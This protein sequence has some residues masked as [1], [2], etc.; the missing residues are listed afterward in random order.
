M[1]WQGLL[2]RFN[3][4]VEK[5]T[6]Q[7]RRRRMVMERLDRREV[8]A[9]NIGAIGGVAF[10]DVNGNST[11]DNGTDI[12][13]VGVSV[14]LFNDTN[15]NGTYDVG[16]D[17]LAG[18]DTTDGSGVYRF[19]GLGT[20]T[21]FIEQAASGSL[22]A[23]G[24]QTVTVTND[25]GVQVAQ[26]DSYETATT[27]I[28]A[29]TGTPTITAFTTAA[30]AIGGER[31]SQVTYTAGASSVDLEVDAA[32][33]L[34][35]I[36]SGPGTSGVALLQYDGLDGAI[37]LDA[38]GLANANLSGGDAAS[39]LEVTMLGD[40]A[41][42]TLV[43][44]IYTDGANSS[45]TTVNIPS[46]GV[47]T[48]FFVPFTTFTTASGAGA[49]FTDVGAIEATFTTVANLDIQVSIVESL[50]PEVV[51][52]NLANTET[53]E[54]GGV[55][56][57]D[58]GPNAG[59]QNNGTNDASEGGVVG[60]DVS[61][62]Q[63]T[64]QADT[65]T[66]ASVAL[67]TTTTGVGGVY[68]FASLTPGFYIVAIDDANFAGAAALAGTVSSTGNDPAPDPDTDILGDDNGT[69]LAGV[70]VVTGVVELTSGGEPTTDGDA[71]NNTNL[72][73][74]F[75]VIP[76][77]D[78]AITKTV[79]AASEDFAGGTALFDISV[80][81][82]GP[83]SATN[84]DFTDVIP[85]GL[86]FVGI[87]NP[88]A[89]FT[90]S[91]VGSTLT[92]GLGTIPSSGAATFQ[93]EATIDAGRTTDITNTGTVA[94]TDQVDTDTA[95]NSD[96]AILDVQEADLAIVKTDLTDPINAG[97]NQ[98][99]TMVV[100]NNGPDASAG[101]VVT[102]VLPAGLTFVSGDVGGNAGL[103]SEA[104]GTITATIGA[105][106]NGATATVTVIVTVAAD[107]ASPLSNTATVASTPNT[108]PNAADNTS[109]ASTVV[110]RV[111]DVQVTKTVT[112]TPIAGQNFTY[113]VSVTNNGP[114]DAR[115]VEV[116]DVLD[117]DLTFVSLNAGT[118]GATSSQTGQ[119][120]TFTLGTLASGATANFS[121]DVTLASD[122]TGTL[123]NTATVATTDTDSNAANNDDT[124][125]V[126]TVQQTDLILTK[127]V[128]LATAVPGQSQLVYTFVVSHDTGS[129]S[130]ATNVVVTDVLPSG[131]SGQI[132]TAATADGTN[133]DTG[134]GTATITFN[135][136]PAGQ[137]RTFTITVDVDEDSTG[138][139]VNPASVASTNDN[140]TSNNS[141]SAT[142]ALTPTFDVTLTKTVT[143]DTLAPT[144]TAT[145]TIAMTNAGPST[146]T[147]V[148]LTDVIPA[149]LTFVS[150]TV[151]STAATSDGTTVTFPGVSI[152]SGATVNATLVFTVDAASSGTITNTA[153]V[154]AD[155]GE[156][157][158]ANNSAS[159]D[160]TVTPEVDLAITK[161]VD[162]TT[163]Q[164]GSALVYTITVTNN[165]PS[166]ATT[167]VATDTLP[168]GVTFVSGVGPAS[169]AL[170]ATGG[171]VTVN[172][173][174]LASGASFTYTING[175]V[176]AGATGNLTNSVSVSNAVAETATANNSATAVTA[177]DP[178][179][180]T[181]TG[182][183]FNDL[184]D[185][186]VQ[187]TGEAGI[188]GVLLTLTGTDTLGQAV[189]ATATTDANGAYSF[190]NLAGGTYTVTQTQPAGFRDGQEIV[191][192]GA[193]ATA[194]DNVF[195]NLGLGADTDALAFNF[196][197]LA[198]LL[199]KR[200][201][202]ASSN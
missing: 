189:N 13:L 141:S 99:Y 26:I 78:L 148:V 177:V 9:S 56:F 97:N 20:G 101:V 63:V 5:K 167:I 55:V 3:K 91:L 73:L 133:F 29:D 49:T 60:V 186:G 171:V 116:T 36:S 84:V 83:A 122:A 34:L 58:D 138:S 75:G 41:G 191:G 42:G 155:T 19:D 53:V 157:S 106:A 76:A 201:F 16:T 185:D 128:D 90:Q 195:T 44:D 114:G 193:T 51:A 80:T 40:N 174:S 62:Y 182:L 102:D 117:A 179:T 144:D 47:L 183:V 190:A 48:E 158:T 22:I 180:S 25:G 65:I 95:N 105:L 100:T 10:T 156:T 7:A 175:T 31:D 111:V 50:R 108:D 121:F 35:L 2:K 154:T 176:A 46:T 192:T 178:E 145:Y 181:I 184:D 94:V 166:T 74:D 81:N 159:D 69:F 196:A 77:V 72:S 124:I 98:T 142:T 173:A 54:V 115:G 169:E 52:A 68:N 162:L 71:D 109:T 104:A 170:T 127:T 139:V 161:S 21:F 85:A 129:V 126:A 14:S 147:N 120:M 15:T 103:V 160:I 198:E 24:V 96:S 131:V 45:T 28:A 6:R 64:S 30:E 87:N 188:A 150:G 110:N 168:T 18:T 151:N 136:I 27:T 152:A 163:A 118:S 82:T 135:A 202:L 113:N 59:E 8:L 130:D 197:E 39:G 38:T 123:A 112:G 199:S 93:I 12:D 164:I 43:I 153:N 172:S 165:G 86:T 92:L 187:D 119:T 57:L 4:R 125:N 23:P 70:G 37:T 32:T 11:Y 143:D 1:V 132:I 140:D 88:S 107:A 194:A 149:G 79:A 146:A 66:G 33:D 17:T 134:T 61:L 200:R 137:T 67:A 89:A